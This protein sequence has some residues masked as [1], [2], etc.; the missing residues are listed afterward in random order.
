MLLLI[1]E[2]YRIDLQQIFLLFN[3]TVL[4]NAIYLQATG[5]WLATRTASPTRAASTS[6]GWSRPPSTRSSSRAGTGRAGQTPRRY[7]S[8]PPGPRVNI[9]FVT[10][11]HSKPP[12]PLPLIVEGKVRRCCLGYKIDSIP[13]RASYCICTRT[14]RR[15]GL[16]HPILHIVLVQFILFFIS[17]WCNSS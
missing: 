7:S 10:V 3:I 8:S 1:F 5:S 15:K 17:S 4:T 11:L 12:S 9:L 6:L 16:M 14:I 13:C 2:R